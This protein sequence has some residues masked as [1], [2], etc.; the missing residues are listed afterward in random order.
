[1]IS[2]SAP[3]FGI[4]RSV[5]FRMP[6]RVPERRM[7]GLSLRK[8]RAKISFGSLVLGFGAGDI[9]LVSASRLETVKKPWLVP[10]AKRKGEFEGAVAEV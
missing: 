6:L 5:M 8:E 3:N 4:R 1:M 10:K 2:E 9:Q 7:K